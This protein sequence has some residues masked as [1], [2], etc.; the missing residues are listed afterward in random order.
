MPNKRDI[1]PFGFTDY[2]LFWQER[3]RR[4]R[5]RHACIECHQVIPKGTVY[6]TLSGKWET[7]SLMR[8]KMCFAC[9]RDWQEL[10]DLLKDQD[11]EYTGTLKEVVEAQFRAGVLSEGHPLVE[12]WIT[13]FAPPYQADRRQ[14]QFLFMQ[15]DN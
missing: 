5:K 14:L 13:L 11:A 7:G 10:L 12:K 1:F 15:E 6:R 9:A 8:F 4:A 2:P 3:Y